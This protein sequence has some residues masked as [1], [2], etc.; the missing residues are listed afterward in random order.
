MK[1]F[2]TGGT[3][4]IGRHVVRQLVERGYQVTALTRSEQGAT[5]LTELGARPV[6]GDILDQDSMREGMKGSDVV[7]HIAGW[8]S[9]GGRD[10]MR[11]ESINVAGARNVLRLAVELR[12]PRIIYTST[13]A[14]FGNTHGRV[15]DE[16]FFQ[17]GPFATEYD[18]TKWL[19]H[20]KV[21]LPLIEQGAP[22]TIVM[23][24]GVYGPGDH[25]LVGQLM[26]RF[27]WRQ[28]PAIPGPEFGFTYAHVE[29]IA[30]GHILAAEKGRP[31]E[32]YIL[33]GPAI[34]LGELIDFWGQLTGIRP[35]ALKVPARLIQPFAPL[36]DFLG[37]RF[38]LPMLLS[39]DGARILGMTYMGRSDKARAKLGWRTRS[40]QEGMTETFR[41]IA[42]T[43]PP[44]P[45]ITDRERKTIGF[46]LLG[47]AALLTLL[48]LSRRRR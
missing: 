35:P 40:L 41:W 42:G 33:T 27:Y 17:G 23:P 6:Y 32:T 46:S 8:Y 38:D 43:P 19:A 39:A 10:W 3:G 5:R 30:H 34:P 7:F 36:L 44:R 37:S 2:V 9:L 47:V 22:I 18:R 12:I 13:T 25:S 20:Y 26:E 24:G 14:V 16:T 11:A 45:F 29:D 1:A 21:A 48:L 28:L 31:G 15:V 4:F